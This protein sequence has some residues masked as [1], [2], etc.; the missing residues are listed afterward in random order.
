M[1]VMTVM[2]ATP[3]AVEKVPAGLAVREQRRRDRLRGGLP[4][5]R[6]VKLPR[7]WQPLNAETEDDIKPILN[8]DRAGRAPQQLANG[9]L[10]RDGKDRG[11]AGKLNS[12]LPT[13]K[14]ASSSEDGC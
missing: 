6:C 1:T 10:D 3:M 5:E 11:G 9:V 4:E 13:R 12:W 2:A 14:K 7:D 8:F